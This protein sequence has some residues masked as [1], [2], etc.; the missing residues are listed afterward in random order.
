MPNIQ[1]N[2]DRY[3]KKQENTHIEN[4]IQLKLTQKVTLMKELVDKTFKIV[5]IIVFCKFKRLEERL[6]MSR[7]IEIRKNTLMELL[8]MAI[9]T[10][11][12]NTFHENYGKLDITG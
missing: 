1:A 8:V 6:D 12:K 9:I 4:K 2:I 10:E 3:S 11:I 5:I 7:Y